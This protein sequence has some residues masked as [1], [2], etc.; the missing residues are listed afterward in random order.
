MP[1]FPA[2]SADKPEST[3]APTNE[4]ANATEPSP[5]SQ[6][7]LRAYL[8]LQEQL[9]SA[10]LAIEQARK[11]ADAAAQRNHEAIQQARDESEAAAQRNTDLIGARLKLIEQTLTNQRD[12][13]MEALHKSNRFMLTIAAVVGGIGFVGMLFTAFCFWRALTRVAQITASL[14]P[15]HALGHNSHGLSSP[16]APFVTLNGPEMSSTRLLGA[17]ERLEK[18]IHDLEHTALPP[19]TVDVE[20]EGPKGAGEK[21]PSVAALLEKGQALLSSNEPEK[22]LR[23]FEEVL[24]V[25]PENA[26]ALV[27]KGTALEQLKRL[28]EAIDCYDKAIALNQTMTV[29]YLHKGAVFNQ[30]ERFSE[31]LECYEQALRT[32]QRP[33]A[34]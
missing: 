10:L 16:D 7:S 1:L 20:S 9:H 11:D 30:L 26:E 4:K 5:E 19:H 32:Q 6:Q 31:A 8:Q 2:L 22:A 29:A 28:E 14:Q 15:L 13:E 25:E 23:C 27:K 24:A 3:P 33:V 17:I 12:R 34:S 18:R 21:T